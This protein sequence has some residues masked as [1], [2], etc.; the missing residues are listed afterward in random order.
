MKK[1]ILSLCVLFMG[2]TCA[3]HD[4]TTKHRYLWANYAQ[5]AGKSD[6][7][8]W[9]NELFSSKIPPYAYKGYLCFLDENHRY[10]EIIKLMPSLEG[11]FAQDPTVQRIFVDALSNTKQ[12]KKAEILI[13]QLS[14][15]FKT[16]P[17]IALR[18]AQA[19]LGRKETKN[20]LLT[21]NAFLNNAPRRPNNFIFHFL[22][23]HIHVQLNNLPN[24]LESIGK[25]LEMHPHFE[26]GWLL[27]A[28]LH[29]K[30][31]K[32]AEAIGEYKTFL[33]LSGS[34]RQVEQ[35]IFMLML[36]QKA[37][38]DSKQ[39]LPSHQISLDNALILFKQQRYQ[40]ALAYIDRCIQK[41]PQNY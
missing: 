9:Y 19:Y 3:H 27:S 29:E 32:I 6:A 4:A 41:Q 20:A 40:E 18:A 14:Q 36:K 16:D 39:Q 24:A 12:H 7:K 28:A 17:D 10:A 33:E 34:N 30:E 2:N 23:S 11:K 8:D 13:I 5:L 15:S 22:E 38:E 37:I 35:Q 21:I 26:K 25:C 1:S 31:G